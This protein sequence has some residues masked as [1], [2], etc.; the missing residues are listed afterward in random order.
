M[1]NCKRTADFL[2]QPDNLINFL[3]HINLIFMDKKVLIGIAAFALIMVIGGVAFV[4]HNGTSTALLNTSGTQPQS[5]S[6]TNQ[7]AQN[8]SKVLFANTQYAPYSY[9][10]YP[11]PV[12]QQAQAALAGFNLTASA[13][14]NRS[15]DLTV[16]LVGTN[17]YQSI[18]LKPSY[19]LY[20][21]E[22]TFGDDGFHFDSSLGDD[23]FV[24]VD[25]NG[26][27]AQ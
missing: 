7:T 12:S 21:V 2:D 20:I 15:T 18:L 5:A 3:A 25:Q 6:A 26:Y 17:Q 19:K 10:V 24:V 8:S 13:L 1:P 23:G 22:T 14:Q 11:G 9:E 16:T 4:A 27:V